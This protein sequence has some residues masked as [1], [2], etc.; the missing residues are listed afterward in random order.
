MIKIRHENLWLHLQWD[1]GSIYDITFFPVSI[2]ARAK[3]PLKRR[4]EKTH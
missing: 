1:K 2:F 3:N 4:T